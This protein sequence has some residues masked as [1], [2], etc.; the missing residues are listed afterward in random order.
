MK[1][2]IS[3]KNCLHAAKHWVEGLFEQILFRSF[4][5]VFSLRMDEFACFLISVKKIGR[6]HV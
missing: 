5:V 1:I 4:C 6:A 3:E 2:E